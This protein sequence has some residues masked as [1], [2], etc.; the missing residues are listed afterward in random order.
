MAFS[1]LGLGEGLVRQISA[2]GFKDPK[3]IQ[4]QCIPPI[5]EGKSVSRNGGENGRVVTFY[6]NIQAETA[7]AALRLGVARRLLLPSPFSRSFPKTPMGF[8]P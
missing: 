3:A 8:S 5:L 6:S 1:S 4:V 2:V 7:W